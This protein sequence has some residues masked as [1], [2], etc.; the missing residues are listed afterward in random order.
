MRW[1]LY[2]LCMSLSVCAEDKKLVKPR[3]GKPHFVGAGRPKCQMTK[4]K[5]PGTKKWFL[6][7][8]PLKKRKKKE[9]AHTKENKEKRPFY[10]KASRQEPV[11]TD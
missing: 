7:K 8:T 2:F 4:K 1:I 5:S 9:T 10:Q 3:Q 6:S 11:S